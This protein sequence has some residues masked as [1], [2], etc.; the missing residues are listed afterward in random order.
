MLLIRDI[1]SRALTTGYLTLE[2]EN[3]LRQLLQHY[4]EPEDLASFMDLQL[5]AMDGLVKQESKER[6][7][8]CT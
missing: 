8:P 4:N 1:T 5:A 7:I 6:L 3:Q 2:A